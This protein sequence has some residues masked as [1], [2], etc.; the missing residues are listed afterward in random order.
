MGNPVS[1]MVNLGY[2]QQ[3]LCRFLYGI[4]PSLTGGIVVAGSGNSLVADQV[5]DVNACIQEGLQNVYS[6]API[7][8]GKPAHEW[9]FMRPTATL[10]TTPPYAPTSNFLVSPATGTVIVNSGTVYG[11][12]T[13]FASGMVGAILT[14]N[15]TSP[16]PYSGSY[17]ISSYTSATQIGLSNTGVTSPTQLATGSLAS[18][19]AASNATFTYGAVPSVTPAAGQYILVYSGTGS[20]T[21]GAYLITA[22]NGTT[23]CTLSGSPGSNLS[24]VSWAL[25]STNASSFSVNYYTYNLP[26]NFGGLVGPMTYAVGM[27]EYYPPIRIVKEV[28]VR[29]RLSDYMLVMRPEIAAIVTPTISFNDPTFTTPQLTDITTNMATGTNWQ[30]MFYPVPD[31]MYVLSYRMKAMPFMLDAVNQFPLG[32]NIISQLIDSACMAASERLIDDSEGIYNRKYAELL[33]A[34]IDSDRS[35]MSPDSLG[36]TAD[37]A[38]IPAQY[39]DQRFMTNSLMTFMGNVYYALPFLALCLGAL[40]LC[41]C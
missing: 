13:A 5:S 10:T 20:V 17:T 29:R 24:A 7:E 37:P 14:L 28:E 33:A 19:N 1:M 26:A 31:A 16:Y 11:L 23:G 22:V 32:G 18:T 25:S 39:Y 35:S 30:I 6:P 9:S 41:T 36:Y 21:P 8:P 12:G 3:K 34:A 15:A 40:R 2:L 38:D 4:W 27:S